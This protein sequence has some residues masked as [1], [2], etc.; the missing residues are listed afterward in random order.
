MLRHFGK[1]YLVSAHIRSEIF[2]QGINSVCVC[3]CVCV[4]VSEYVYVCVSVSV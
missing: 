3:V 1:F 2:I 4:C